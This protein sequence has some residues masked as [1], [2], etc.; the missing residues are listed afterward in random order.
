MDY[1]KAILV[2][3]VTLVIVFCLNA[4][5]YFGLTR[6]NSSKTS[7]GQVDLLRKAASRAKDPWGVENANLSELSLLTN[8]LRDELINEEKTSVG[9]GEENVG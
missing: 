6:R 3:I 4:V 1:S 8:R 7:I 2:V 9:N 5:I